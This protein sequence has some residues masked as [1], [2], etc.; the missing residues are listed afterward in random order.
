MLLSKG[1]ITEE[2]IDML[3][4]RPHSGFNVSRGKRKSTNQ[5]DLK[6]SILEPEGSSSE[7][8]KNWARLTRL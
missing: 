6:P 7:Y 1:K 4:N 8:R 2:M 5:D 3:M